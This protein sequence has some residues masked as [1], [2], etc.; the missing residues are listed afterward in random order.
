MAEHIPQ[1]PAFDTLEET[2]SLGT[3]WKKWI[4]RFENLMV[5]MN[6]TDKDRKR[7][8]LLHL[9]GEQVYDI[10]QI[11]PDTTPGE[12]EDTFEKAKAALDAHFTPQKNLEYETYKFRKAEQGKD[13]TLAQYHT[14]L[15]ELAATCEF[16]NDDREIKT[17]IVQHCRSSKL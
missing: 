9:A 15:R 10:F 13:E 16:A 5:A 2:N 1:F 11:L 4:A 14:R 3:R 6:V 17:Q 8:L 12:D 7:A